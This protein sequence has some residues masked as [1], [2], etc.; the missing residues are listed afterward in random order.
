MKKYHDQRIEKRQFVVGYL[1]LL[2]NSR[3]C[4]FLGKLMSMWSKPFL[5]K[6][7]FSHGALELENSEGTKFK[8]NRHRMKLYLK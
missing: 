3:L 2:L 6:Q 1:A 5:N 8:V 4:L 7:V